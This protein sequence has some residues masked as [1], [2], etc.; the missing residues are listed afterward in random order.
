MGYAYD[1]D[2]MKDLLER[3]IQKRISDRSRQWL[4]KQMQRWD[5]QKKWQYF[6]VTFTAIPRFVDKQPVDPDNSEKKAISDI[7]SGLHIDEWTLDRLIRTWW[8]LFVPTEDAV[9]YTG[10]LDNLFRAAE[11]NEQVALYGA[12][13]LLAYPDNLKLRAAE[14]IRTN[15]GLVF[16]AVA[17]DNPYPAEYLD[18]PA[19]NQMVLKA[20]F[21]DKPTER[22]IGIDKRA[23]KELAHILSDY[24]HERWSAGR[25]VNPL[26]WRPVGQFID[27]SI[28]PDIRRLF[29]VGDE[30]EKKAAALACATSRFGTA[31][32]ILREYPS[33]SNQIADGSLTWE[34]VALEV[35]LKH[36]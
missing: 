14:G 20:F 12:L 18:K 31:E 24:A 16:E 29:S 26:L 23:N 8:L 11:M 30:T 36:A 25:K 1:A 21:M 32:V 17:L 34:Q 9:S 28:M 3:M 19:W 4:D 22:I 5:Q 15:I 13:P 2:R 35:N 27:E 33:L 7:R 6:N 10:Q